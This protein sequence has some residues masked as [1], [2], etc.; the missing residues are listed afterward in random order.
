MIAIPGIGGIIKKFL[1]DNL[2]AKALDFAKGKLRGQ[3]GR[4]AGSALGQAS[5]KGIA[6]VMG[7]G[8]PG[9]LDQR[10]EIGTAFAETVAVQFEQAAAS[11]RAFA[12]AQAGRERNRTGTPEAVAAAL[13]AREKAET[14]LLEDCVDIGR[15]LIG[16]APSE[17]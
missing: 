4:S 7:P 3:L 10:I 12:V 5:Y 9:S 13:E 16:D 17:R 11:I 15:V 6:T 2:Q 8:M 14:D 1:P